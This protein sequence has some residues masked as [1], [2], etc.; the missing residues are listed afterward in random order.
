MK[1]VRVANDNISTAFF[2]VKAGT[3]T[4][5]DVFKTVEFYS[6]ATGLAVDTAGKGARIV[7]YISSTKGTCQ[8]VM[9]NTETA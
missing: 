2:K 1:Y 6:D 9:P 8:F 3:F 7:G 5:A 4:A